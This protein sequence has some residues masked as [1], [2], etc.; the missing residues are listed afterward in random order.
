MVAEIVPAVHSFPVL[1]AVTAVAL[2]VGLGRPVRAADA[3]LDQARTE[4]ERLGIQTAEITAQLEQLT[5][6]IT[7]ANTTRER[8]ESDLVALEAAATDAQT[9]VTAQAVHAYMHGGIG[10]VA[11]LL[12]AVAPREAMER[13]RT[14][15]GLTLRERELGERALLARARLASRR[16]EL[17]RLLVGLQANEARVAALRAELEAAFTRAQVTET[18]LASRLSRQREVSR[19]GQ[20]GIYACPI[21]APFTFRDTW[22]APRS[23]GRRHKGVDIFGP[24]G[25]DVY[26]ITAGRILRHSNSGLGGLGLYLSGDDGNVYYYAHLASIEPGY[27]TGR[28]VEA[29]E[30]IAFNGNTGNARGGAAHIHFEV[31]PGGGGNV[32]P[33]PF[34]AAAC[35]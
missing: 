14:L 11:E 30:L 28:R 17:D 16:L 6:A 33:Y 5:V 35:L 7:D 34:T 8:L 13:A 22:G 27:G 12:S 2:V 26:A 10:P 29:G 32:N 18:R 23:G 19:D 21:A 25:A 3:E 20:R 9:V 1:A 15:A 24:Y 31:R 4:R